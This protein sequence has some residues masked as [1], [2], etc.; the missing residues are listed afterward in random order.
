M[1]W[2]T[3]RQQRREAREQ[4]VRD[5]AYDKAINQGQTPEDAK[6]A[7]ERAVRRRR[8]IRRAAIITAVDK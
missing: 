5:K 2:F 3:A 8:R 6:L 1:G 7:A 4:R